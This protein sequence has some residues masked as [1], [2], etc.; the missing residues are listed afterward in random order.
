MMTIDHSQAVRKARSRRGI[1]MIEMVVLMAGVAT[2]LGICAVLLQ[3]LMKLD[4]DSR[5]RLDRGRPL[6]P[7]WPNSSAGMFMLLRRRR[8][9]RLR[10]PAKATPG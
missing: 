7:G 5:A 6:P 2:M 1:S 10:P 9:W 3:L 4:A 8:W